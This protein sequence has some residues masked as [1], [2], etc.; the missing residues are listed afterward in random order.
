MFFNETRAFFLILGFRS[1]DLQ[2][3]Y[4]CITKSVVSFL[5]DSGAGLVL[6]MVIVLNSENK[7]IIAKLT[8]WVGC[9]INS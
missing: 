4:K 3:I 7:F 9:I 8:M 2:N 1:L 6:S 5:T